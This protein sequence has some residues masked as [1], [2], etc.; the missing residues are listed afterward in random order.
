VDDP[1]LQLAE[2]IVAGVKSRDPVRVH[3]AIVAALQSYEVDDS[4]ANVFT[5]ALRR[6]SRSAPD[7]TVLLAALRSHVLRALRGDPI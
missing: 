1:R 7:R 5:P 4:L 2:T 6:V 3:C